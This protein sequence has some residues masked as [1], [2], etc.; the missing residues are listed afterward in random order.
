MLNSL[1]CD[2]P[3]ARLRARKSTKGGAADAAPA[4]V[5]PPEAAAPTLTDPH[6]SLMG[7]ILAG[8]RLKSAASRQLPPATQPLATPREALLDAIKNTSTTTLRSVT[9]EGDLVAAAAPAPA[10]DVMAD[11]ASS[12]MRRRAAIVSDDDESDSEG[13]IMPVPRH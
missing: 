10:G 11:L 13:R 2:D 3:L 12:I 4:Q 1:V 9:R 6:A 5:A 8:P 7:A